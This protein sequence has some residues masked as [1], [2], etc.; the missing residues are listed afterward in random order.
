[1]SPVL[2]G[3]GEPLFTG[4][5]LVALGFQPTSFVAT[6]KASHYVLERKR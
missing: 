2:L 3:K 1:V 6:E 5:D 4:I